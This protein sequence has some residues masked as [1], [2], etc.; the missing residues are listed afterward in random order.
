MWNTS[1]MRVIGVVLG[2]MVAGAS[3]V[4][5]VAFG[6]VGVLPQERVTGVENLENEAVTQNVDFAPFWEAWNVINDRYVTNEAVPSQEK[7]WGAIQGLANSL[8][9]PYTVFLPPQ[10]L[11]AFETEISGNFE[12][13]GMEVGLRD[14]VLT[15]IAPLKGTPAFRAGI[16]SGDKII[17][18]DN[19][20]TNQF[21]IDE[22]VQKIRGKQGTVVKLTI[23][24]DG[25][26]EPI[27]I[28]VV[29][30]VIDI[31]TVE[32][33][34]KTVPGGGTVEGVGN[35]RDDGI[36]IIR[37]FNFSAVSPNLFRD[38]LRQFVLSGSDKLILDLR[39]NPGGYLEAAVDIASW[40][41]PP[42]E[43][44]VRED[45]GGARKE[46]VIRSKGY[47][48]FNDSLKFVILIDG[49]SA[50][51]SEILAGALRE[52]KKATLVGTQTFGKGSVQELVKITPDTSLKIT[53]ARW[54]TPEGVSISEKGIT[55]DVVVPM[56]SADRD[57]GAD[58][59][60][61]KAVEILLGS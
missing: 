54:L 24:R 8:G 41:L 47:D 28:S 53:I 26:D 35:I 56:T 12:G 31:P 27:E 6:R 21:T 44:V 18:I 43:V 23:L 60:L 17:R 52:Y 15:V 58:P 50:S 7:V 39:G 45:F 2:V 36:F 37:L 30:G 49:G 59:Q 46:E 20:L 29:R 25:E 19:E 3:F 40:F 16:L 32:T 22:A 33:E 57:A 34:V 4:V 51:A 48:I 38:A 13:V 14:G 61:E 11:E 10:E 1:Y 55:P 9:D 42:G 5:G